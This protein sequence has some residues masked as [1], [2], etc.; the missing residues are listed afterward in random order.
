M[1]RR[2]FTLTE[3]L[4]TV[5]IIGIMAGAAMP[6]FA[7]TMERSY[8]RE[9]ETLLLTTYAGEQVFFTLNDTYYAPGFWSNIYM[10]NPNLAGIPVS[11]T[12]A[13]TGSGAAATFTGTAQRTGGG[14][15]N[16]RTLTINQTR[17]F[18]GTWS[19]CPGL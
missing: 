11:F 3:V 12:A 19:T 1:T 7:R 16:G 13:A 4:V 17:T 5:A 9:A 8:F 10:D 14:L 18:G 6:Q 15:C 2:A